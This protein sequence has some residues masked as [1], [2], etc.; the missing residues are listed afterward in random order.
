MNDYRVI[1]KALGNRIRSLRTGL[2]LSQEEFAAV[3]ELD[4][5]YISGVERGLRNISFI[6]LY[7]IASKLDMPLSQL[8]EIQSASTPKLAKRDYILNNTFSTSCGF[9][10]SADNVHS[11]VLSSNDLL[12]ELP[13]HLY[14]NIDLKTLSSIVGALF[15]ACLAQNVGAIVNPIEKGHPDIIPLEGANASEEQLRNY[16]KGLEIK[17]TVGNVTTGSDLTPGK[18]R[19][20][21]LSDITWQAHHREVTQLMGLVTDFAGKAIGDLKYPIITGVF[22]SDTL[23]VDD[24]GAISG[25]T[26]RNTKVTGM[27]KSGK[28]KMGHRWVTILNHKDYRN[29]Y[30]ELLEIRFS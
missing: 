23:S 24:W 30:Q 16:P 7:A 5:T 8:L 2:G 12:E 19:I 28:I 20:Q 27:R 3:C 13:F 29:T 14:T 1:L 21:H 6:N 9:N 26:G 15:C 25:T 22:Y 11:A 17:T 10:V 4:R 18:E